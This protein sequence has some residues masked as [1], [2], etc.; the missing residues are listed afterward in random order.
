MRTALTLLLGASASLAGGQLV[1]GGFEDGSTGWE[2]H[3]HAVPDTI[4]FDLEVPSGGGAKSLLMPISTTQIAAEHR[5]IQELGT[6][7]PGT[8]VQF[9]GWMRALVAGAI[10]ETEP[11][12]A[13]C[14]C[15]SAGNSTPIGPVLFYSGPQYSWTFQQTT[16]IIAA[17]PPSG[18]S[19]C[20]TLASGLMHQ[21]FGFNVWYDEV[22]FSVDPSTST[23][24]VE[25]PLVPTSHPNPATDKLRV[26]LL[27]VPLTITA[28]DASGRTHDLKS[29]IHRDHILEVDVDALP[30]GICSL[31][32]TTAS[33]THSI[34]FV[35]A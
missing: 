11:S 32:I 27:E 17:A 8:V 16:M 30:A 20:L 1:N 5:V 12:I 18:H 24:D 25:L 35:K 33:G 15:D 4:S 28:I 21:N 31:R 9:G 23:S 19:H 7:A 26:D 6:L 22:F 13:L 10:F 14:T 29:F 2:V 34:R 3:I